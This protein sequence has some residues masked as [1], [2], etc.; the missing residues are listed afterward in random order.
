MIGPPIIGSW[1]WKDFDAI[2]THLSVF[3][4]LRTGR[5]QLLRD[6]AQL[7]DEFVQ[8]M[9]CGRREEKQDGG[10]AEWGASRIGKYNNRSFD[11]ERARQN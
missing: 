9:L 7:G 11:V 1:Y 10:R 3:F 4:A 6:G 8:Q 2:A 5:V